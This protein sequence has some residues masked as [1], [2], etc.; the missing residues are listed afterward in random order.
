MD[1]FSKM[2]TVCVV[3][4]ALFVLPTLIY[5]QHNDQVT[6]EYVSNATVEFVDNVLVQGEITQEMYESFIKEID[7]T[8]MVYDVEFEYSKKVI[9]P[10]AGGT[11]QTTTECYYF[12]DV[13]NALYDSSS[14]GATI[15]GT[16]DG[17]LQMVKGDY[18]SVTVKNRD[19]TH[20]DILQRSLFKL[21]S[22]RSA[23]E[24]NY[25]GEVRDENYD[26]AAIDESKQ[27][28]GT[29][30]GSNLKTTEKKAWKNSSDTIVIYKNRGMDRA[31]AFSN[32]DTDHDSILNKING[33]GIPETDASAWYIDYVCKKSTGCELWSRAVDKMGSVLNEG[34]G[35]NTALKATEVSDSVKA[36]FVNNNS[37]YNKSV[38]YSGSTTIYVYIQTTASKTLVLSSG[39]TVSAGDTLT[40]LL[41]HYCQSNSDATLAIVDD[42]VQFYGE[43]NTWSD[44]K[45]RNNEKDTGV[46]SLGQYLSN[47]PNKTRCYT[48]VKESNVSTSGTTTGHSAS[49]YTNASG[50]TGS[51]GSTYSGTFEVHRYTVSGKRYVVLVKQPFTLTTPTPAPTP[52]PTVK[53]TVAPTPKPTV[54]PTVAPTPKATTAP[55]GTS[56]E[57]MCS[58]IN[59]NISLE[60][61]QHSTVP[62]IAIVF[63]EQDKRAVIFYNSNETGSYNLVQM[64][65][66]DQGVCIDG[67]FDLQSLS[68]YTV[69]K[70][71]TANLSGS[72][73]I[74]N[75]LKGIAGSGNWGTTY[76][77]SKTYKLSYD[78]LASTSAK[79]DELAYLILYK[80]Q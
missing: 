3:V 2:I 41:K 44:L 62:G 8:G 5:A 57:N 51:T 55:S 80:M 56:Y 34:S 31:F 52:K 71:D 73:D 50:G 21:Y 23:V 24:V 38:Y 78:S 19:A 40:T 77:S 49:S 60:H 74:E 13:K 33:A 17:V 26:I 46:Y 25:G 10:A 29:V 58:G 53:P 42:V 30:F 16:T 9:T 35:F 7:S 6:Q 69:R 48:G 15:D 4:V 43:W 14:A 68:S 70:V 28:T 36:Y 39:S 61:H 66:H 75:N 45:D 63:N 32:S 20:S 11:Y 64:M 47:S 79:T 18:F 54:K 59:Y 72:D 22:N 27:E 65:M 76:F 1:A 37:T 12:D 67:S